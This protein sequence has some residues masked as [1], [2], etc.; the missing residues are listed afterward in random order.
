V[1][2]SSGTTTIRRGDGPSATMVWPDGHTV[3]V[4]MRDGLDESVAE[5]V[6]ASIQVKSI[7]ELARMRTDLSDRLAAGPVLATATVPA[8]RLELIGTGEPTAICLAVAG[9]ERTCT[10]RDDTPYWRP[11]P[12]VA[13]SIVGGTWY[14]FAASRNPIDLT[15][16]PRTTVSAVD[17]TTTTTGPAGARPTTVKAIPADTAS[18]GGWNFAVLSVPADPPGTTASINLDT[19]GL[20]FSRPAL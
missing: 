11:T 13:S 4:Q 19:H 10:G 1:A 18:D 8:G 16:Q 2:V 7:A 17:P 3:I 14:V 9:G 20:N 12:I 6:G 15:G 5:R